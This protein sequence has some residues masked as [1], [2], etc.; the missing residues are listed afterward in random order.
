MGAAM[1]NRPIG[2]PAAS[3]GAPG[4]VDHRHQTLSKPAQCRA[5]VPDMTALHQSTDLVAKERRQFRLIF[6]VVFMVFLATSLIARILPR[7]LR[8]WAQAGERRQSFVAEARAIA[9]TVVP[10]A[11]L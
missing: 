7:R 11:F 4:V 6:G 5:G 3:V 10:F 9:N 8:P 1:T 2:E